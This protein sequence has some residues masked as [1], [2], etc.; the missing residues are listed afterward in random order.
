MHRMQ[1]KSALFWNKYFIRIEKWIPDKCGLIKPAENLVKKHIQ[2]RE[3]MFISGNRRADVVS[4]QE[5]KRSRLKCTYLGMG[6]SDVND[7]LWI[8]LLA[9]LR[10]YL[11]IK[12][13]NYFVL[14]YWKYFRRSNKRRGTGVRVPNGKYTTT[15]R[16]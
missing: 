3:I 8:Y 11:K 2:K 7:Y 16:D 13:L 12:M 15:T 5:I 9:I 10:E 1:R 6:V 14:G 4:V